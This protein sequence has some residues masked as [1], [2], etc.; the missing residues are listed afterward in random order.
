MYCPIL[1]KKEKKRTQYRVHHDSKPDKFFLLQIIIF[2]IQIYVHYS[3]QKYPSKLR[4]VYMKD[5]RVTGKSMC[6]LIKH[7]G[8]LLTNLTKTK[9]EQHY[10][11]Q[12]MHKFYGYVC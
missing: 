1:R 8:N 10:N 2:N 6:M 11:L 5:V 9:S 4:C 3:H 7:H 12:V